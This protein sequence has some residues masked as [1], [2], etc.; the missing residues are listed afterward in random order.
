MCALSARAAIGLKG[1]HARRQAPNPTCRIL[2]PDA[3]D[4]CGL[5]RA[6]TR[7]INHPMQPAV[8]APPSPADAATAAAGW[9]SRVEDAT[10]RAAVAMAGGDLHGL[11]AIF[12]E[13][14]GWDDLQRAYQAPLREDPVLVQA[15][16]TLE[17]DQ[18]IQPELYRAVAEALAGAYQLSRER[19]PKAVA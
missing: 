8:P 18:E 4:G 2:A 5:N 10:D 16:A 7:P 12:G 19:P 11:D 9:R 15:L 3:A 14:D 17:L 1:N 13:L 6:L